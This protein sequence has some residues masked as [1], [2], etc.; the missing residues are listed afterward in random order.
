[1][2]S[3][4]G[5]AVERNLIAIGAAVVLVAG[6]VAGAAVL[7][8]LAAP[9][10]GGG[11]DTPTGTPSASGDGSGGGTGGGGGGSS[12]GDGASG[13]DGTPTPLPPLQLRVDS[14]ESCGDTCR[15]VTATL[16]NNQ[17][18]RA[19]GV[20]VHTTI[21]AGESR[22]GDVVWEGSREV[23]AIPAGGSETDTT[24]VELG[25]FEAAKVQSAGGHITIETVVETDRRTVTFVSHRDVS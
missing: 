15:D 16:L 3:P 18:R 12:D 1:M 21:H 11:D 5:I 20:T 10:S 9:G 24:K 4:R 8:P 13:G 25:Y 19:T 23:G 6:L 17:E 7:G 22:E 2:A 14:I